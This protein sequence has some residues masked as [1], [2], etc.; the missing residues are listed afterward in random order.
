MLL[1]M[2]DCGFDPPR[3]AKAQIAAA[4]HD[5]Y[6][7]Q[8]RCLNMRP[9]TIQLGVA[10]AISP[11]RPDLHQFSAQYIPVESI[12]LFPVRNMNNTVVEYDSRHTMTS[13][14]QME[15]NQTHQISSRKSGVRPSIGSK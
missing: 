12:R 13:G 7:C 8:R 1:K 15:C 10:E 4:R 5:P 3:P 2:R 14:V 9:M 6:R 11:P